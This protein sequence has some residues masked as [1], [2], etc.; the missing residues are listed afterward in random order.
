MGKSRE[1]GKSAAEADGEEQSPFM[2]EE[3][4]FFRH[5][6]KQAQKKATKDVNDK[7]TERES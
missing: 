1:C 3:V 2:A 7:S 5:T 6:I 4:S